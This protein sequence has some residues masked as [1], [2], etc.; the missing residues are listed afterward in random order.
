M[1]SNID[2]L[3]VFYSFLRVGKVT[4]DLCVKLTNS[5]QYLLSSS[6]HPYHHCKRGIPY[7]QAL[8][9]DKTCSDSNFFDRRCNDLEK[10]LIEKVYSEREI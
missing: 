6:C 9:L 5:Q 2:Q 3:L 7:N 10:W 4:T 8:C 1:V